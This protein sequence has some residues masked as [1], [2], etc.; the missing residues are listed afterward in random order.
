MEVDMREATNGGKP[1]SITRQKANM[2]AALKEIERRRREQERTDKTQLESI[3]G[4]AMLA[5]ME[6]N[7][8]LK[9]TVQRTLQTADLSRPNRAFLK[10]KGWL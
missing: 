2:K 9:V 10:S 8:E 5:A 6:R 7:A 3:I 4:S 1:A